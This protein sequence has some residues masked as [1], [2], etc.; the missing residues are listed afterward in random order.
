MIREK[1][2]RNL[3][4]EVPHGIA[5]AIETMK[6][7]K[8]KNIVDID[9]VIVCERN[10]HKGIIIGKQ[11]NMLKKIGTQA[12]QDIESLLACKVN[13][14]LWVKVKKDWRNSDFLVKNFGY[15]KKD[16]D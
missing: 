12:R 10:T 15:N 4:D 13:L 7:R 14:K 3:N 2:L 1:T 8:K 5:V 11:G 16:L 9:A 6:E